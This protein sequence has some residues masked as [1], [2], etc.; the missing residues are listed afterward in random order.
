QTANLLMMM[1]PMQ[2][3]IRTMA[4]SQVSS[5]VRLG[6]TAPHL[7]HA[8]AFELIAVPHSLHWVIAIDRGRAWRLS[9]EAANSDADAACQLFAVHQGSGASGR[10]SPSCGIRLARGN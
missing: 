2:P 4:T 9:F 6:S 1:L 10:F 8:A 3:G 7:G 5:E